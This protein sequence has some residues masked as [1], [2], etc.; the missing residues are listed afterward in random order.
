[1]E[2]PTCVSFWAWVATGAFVVP[3]MQWLKKLPRVGPVLD[4]W[5][6]LVAPMLSTIAPAIATAAS[7]YCGRIDPWAWVALYGGFVYLVSQIAYWVG[8]KAKL[9]A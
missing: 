9:V 1:M 8:K 4:A 7:P 3:L 5:A 6:W 2:V